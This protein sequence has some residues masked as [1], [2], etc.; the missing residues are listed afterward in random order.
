MFKTFEEAILI[1]D[2]MFAVAFQ[3]AGCTY[4]RAWLAQTWNSR[5]IMYVQL[6]RAKIAERIAETKV[7][8]EEDRTKK[9]RKRHLLR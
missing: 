2:E 5:L 6:S 7:P 8:K 1:V 4:L 3:T 9:T